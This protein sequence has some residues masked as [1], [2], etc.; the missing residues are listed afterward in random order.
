[1]VNIMQ[2]FCKIRSVAFRHK[3]PHPMPGTFTG[4]VAKHTPRPIRDKADYENTLDMVDRLA[5]LDD[6]ALTRDQADYLET[7]SRLV[8][9]WENENTP[10][11]EASAIETLCFLMA[12][13]GMN[14]GDVG[15]LVG[16][17]TYGYALL[18]GTRQFSKR[19]MVCLG[20]YFNVNPSVF[21]A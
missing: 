20:E 13:H 18:K 15:R 6:S 4:L 21:L 16:A 3:R 1:M 2:I 9:V 7:L 10:L 12:Q 19:D 17:R 14:A 11:P 8:E 5:A